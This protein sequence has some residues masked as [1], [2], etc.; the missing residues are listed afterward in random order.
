MST[1]LM[2]PF[3]VEKTWFLSIKNRVNTFLAARLQEINR[4]TMISVVS[5]QEKV[6][7][8]VIPPKF[9]GSEKEKKNTT[10]GPCLMRLLGLTLAFFDCLI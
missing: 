1:T 9:R 3:F 2:S 5:I 8:V 10:E 7:A 4:F 6:W